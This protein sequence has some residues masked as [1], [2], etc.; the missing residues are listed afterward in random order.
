MAILPCGE[1]PSV[2]WLDYLWNKGQ[3]TE[4]VRYFIE[5]KC[6]T[7]PLTFEISASDL[8][9]SKYWLLVF[10]DEFA[11]RYLKVK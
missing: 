6:Y 1:H 5:F 9:R 3:K 2:I 11:E 7:E 4:F 10:R 8:D